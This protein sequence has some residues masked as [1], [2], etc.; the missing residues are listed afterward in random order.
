M[1]KFFAAALLVLA[2]CGLVGCSNEA[3]IAASNIRQAADNFGI[4]RRIVFYN[5]I[6]G[7]YIL[8][9]TGLCSIDREPG[10]VDVTCKTGPA[11]YVTHKLGVSDN[12]TWFAEQLRGANV[13]TDHYRVTFKP[14]AIIP[15]VDLR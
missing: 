2:A 13:S 6:N 5:G 8:E 9:I 11:E 7:E 3:N 10:K 15:T 1:R 12:V 14:S 4:Q